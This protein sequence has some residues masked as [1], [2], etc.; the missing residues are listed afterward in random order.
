MH[1]RQNMTAPGVPFR[2][3]R[4]NCVQDDHYGAA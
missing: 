1:R 3:M 2:F 4:L